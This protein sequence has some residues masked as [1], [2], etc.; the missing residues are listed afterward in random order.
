MGIQ[1][2]LTYMSYIS[3]IHE[4]KVFDFCGNLSVNSRSWPLSLIIFISFLEHVISLSIVQLFVIAVEE[5][6]RG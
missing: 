1:D 3:R 4:I 5:N 6:L 2:I